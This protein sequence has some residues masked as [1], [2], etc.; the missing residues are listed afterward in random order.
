MNNHGDNYPRLAKQFNAQRPTQRTAPG[1]QRVK[2]YVTTMPVKS[3][4]VS[5]WSAKTKHHRILRGVLIPNSSLESAAQTASPATIGL[6]QVTRSRAYHLAN[7]KGIASHFSALA[8]SGLRYFVN[9]QP[10]TFFTTGNCNTL[11]FTEPTFTV[12]PSTGP[13]LTGQHQ[14]ETVPSPDSLLLLRTKR[15]QPAPEMLWVPDKE[16]PSLQALRPIAACATII[17]ALEHKREHLNRWWVPTIEGIH[18]TTIRQ[19]QVLDATRRFLAP[20]MTLKQ[21]KKE[22][23]G[24]VDWRLFK[25]IWT[26][27]NH[28][29]DSPQETILRLIVE[30]QLQTLSR[31]TKFVAIPQVELQVAGRRMTSLDLLVVEKGSEL[32]RQLQHTRIFELYGNEE[33]WARSR[34]VGLQYDGEH[35]LMRQQRDFD[36]TADVRCAEYAV[37]VQRVTSAMLAEQDLRTILL[38]LLC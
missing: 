5:K 11:T 33:L 1:D 9:Q 17:A 7:P 8:L 26:Q 37:K 18:A 2:H 27:S 23:H 4:A 31:C 34:H 28:R 35:H 13:A 22:T 14:A 24:L 6:S 19:I 29:S 12:T 30:Q 32:W 16:L 3:A 38:R 36:I 20:T 21:A 10:T 15:I 25:R